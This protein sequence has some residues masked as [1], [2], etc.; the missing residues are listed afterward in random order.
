MAAKLKRR[1][2]SLSQIDPTTSLDHS[3][4][5]SRAIQT[6]TSNT[7]RAI[8]TTT[9]NTSRAIQTTTTHAARERRCSQTMTSNLSLQRWVE[10]V[11]IIDLAASHSRTTAMPLKRWKNQRRHTPPQAK[12]HLT[13]LISRMLRWMKVCRKGLSTKRELTDSSRTVMHHPQI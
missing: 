9:S 1:S 11:Q 4:N 12:S 5:T 8:K 10:A 7:S 3:S 6:T 2:N 13:R